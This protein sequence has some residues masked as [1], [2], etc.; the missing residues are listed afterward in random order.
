MAR[1]NLP[2]TSPTYKD[3]RSSKVEAKRIKKTAQ[4]Y[5]NFK[6]VKPGQVGQPHCVNTLNLFCKPEPLSWPGDV[7]NCKVVILSRRQLFEEALY[8]NPRCRHKGRCPEKACKYSIRSAEQQERRARAE[9][10]SWNKSH[11]FSEFTEWRD[12]CFYD[13]LAW[14]D[15]E[16]ELEHDWFTNEGAL[17][18][19]GLEDQFGEVQESFDEQLDF[20]P[21]V[22]A[23]MENWKMAVTHRKAWCNWT[24]ISA[25]WL[26]SPDYELVE[27]D[28]Q[29]MSDFEL[30]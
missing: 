19:F 7:H 29:F 5:D 10:Q 18:G 4:K 8:T 15:A 3:L 1:P 23:A 2:P 28:E 24:E 12:D 17:N 26:F 16:H 11:A 27:D 6:H 9:A 25:D 30:I 22:D 13:E 21:L 20:G 14:W